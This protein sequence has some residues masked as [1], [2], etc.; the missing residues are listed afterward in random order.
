MT[1]DSENNLWWFTQPETDLAQPQTTSYPLDLSSPDTMEVLP[2]LQASLRDGFMSK[3]SKTKQMYLKKTKKEKETERQRK[4]E[5]TAVPP[6]PERHY[7]SWV[8]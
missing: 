6:V 4:N 1:Y 3:K 8:S 2:S 5:S 7:L